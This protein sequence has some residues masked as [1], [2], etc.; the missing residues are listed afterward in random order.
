[1]G[2]ELR[3]FWSKYFKPGWKFGLS[4][5]LLVCIPRF[6]LVLHANQY[7]NYSTIGLVMLISALVPFL[8]LNKQGLKQ[9]GVRKT[10]SIRF[11]IYAFITGLVF[12]ILLH[13][14]G[15]ML[16][17]N[18]YQNW[19][20]YIGKSYNIPD[21]ISTDGKKTMFIIMASTGMIFS[22][23]GEELFFRG[24]V[25]GSFAK[26][27]G[28]KKASIID[29]LAFALTHISHFGL[30]FVGGS[31]GFYLIPAIIWVTS[32]F[33]VSLLF[34]QM[35]KRTGSIWGAVLCHS[36]FNLGMIYSIFYLL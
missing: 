34:F 10:K 5:L 22:P 7:G 21:G 32:M 4:L 31:W 2:I 19:Y 27:I 12:S 33:V 36:G 8:F 20:E 16:Y 6:I 23:L 25:H 18:S 3:N 17:E 13:F 35:K 26:S 30:V 29:S 28:E 15:T 11:L 9:I 14:L 1:M 24:I